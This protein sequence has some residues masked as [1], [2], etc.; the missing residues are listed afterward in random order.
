MPPKKD[1]KD[2]KAGDKPER[3][4]ADMQH[5]ELMAKETNIAFMHS[6]LGG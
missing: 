5:Q 2:A 4:E 3:T 6:K 1:K